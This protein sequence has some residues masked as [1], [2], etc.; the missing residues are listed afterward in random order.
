MKRIVNLLTVIA[1]G[2][3]IL[4]FSLPLS[5]RAQEGGTNLLVNGGFEYWD[6]DVRSWPFQDG[7]P[8]VQ[9]C[10]G[11]R[12]FFVDSPPSY[13][14]VPKQWRRPEFRDVKTAE[15]ANRVRSGMLA[16]KYFT[17]GGEHEAGLYQQVGG[18]APG[19]PLRF[20]VY[21]QTWSCMAGDQ[22]WSI[23]PTGD[24]S[25]SPAPMHTRAGIDPTG[26]TDPW[27]PNVVWSP[28]IDAYD[29]W[30]PF[31][32]EAV[33]QNSTVTVFTYSRA[34]WSDLIFR[35]HNDVYVDD[36]SLI[37]LNE[38]PP[39]A[40][41]VPATPAPPTP[42][43]PTPVPT[44]APPAVATPLPSPTP[45][46]V[47][48]SPTPA[49]TPTPRPTS[50]STPAPT[51]TSQPS[52]ATPPATATP[53][54]STS[55]AEPATSTP[56]AVALVDTEVP[57]PRATPLPDDDGGSFPLG[58]VAGGLILVFLVFIAVVQPWRSPR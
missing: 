13:A 14:N 5:V 52:T 44:T 21:M 9:V 54:P 57:E 26:G 55:P 12:A 51:A 24:R 28:K 38:V 16:Q 50:T 19:T 37:S 39:T 11:W 34:D 45:E 40:T 2:L 1:L 43:P 8:E 32:V 4:A 31:Q 6:W 33:A 36:A 18:I 49:H 25:N 27:S 56:L 35:I 46:A 42:V 22:G 29:H 48:P 10:P 3:S 41:P 30:V 47:Q 7:I 17:F 15:H 53:L 23:C 20:T 58:L